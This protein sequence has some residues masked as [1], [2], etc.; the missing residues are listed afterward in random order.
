MSLPQP[1]LPGG[2]RRLEPLLLAALEL[3]PELLG[4][5]AGASNKGLEQILLKAAQQQRR[6]LLRLAQASDDAAACATRM[7]AP[8]P[9][10]PACCR[11][12]SCS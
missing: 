6:Q 4:A 8:L 1:E 11:A 5:T 12:P 7:H 3:P 10:H 2:S 9:A